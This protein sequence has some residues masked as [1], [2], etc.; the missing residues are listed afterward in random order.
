MKKSKVH[1]YKERH[2]FETLLI[3]FKRR[4]YRSALILTKNPRH[5]KTMVQ[6]TFK[7]ARKHHSEIEL[8]VNYG[9]WLYKLMINNYMSNIRRFEMK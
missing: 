4:L 9:V 1:N 5:A 2:D 7:S 6:E 3:P 8:D